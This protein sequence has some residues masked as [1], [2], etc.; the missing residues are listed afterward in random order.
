MLRIL[1]V[2]FISTTS[3]LIESYGAFAP[4]DCLYHT[5]QTCTKQ[6]K[7]SEIAPDN[8]SLDFSRKQCIIS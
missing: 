3:V 5:P 4:F 8:S 7:N 2:F 1:F 6:L